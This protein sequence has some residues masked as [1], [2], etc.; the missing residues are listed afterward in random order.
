MPFVSRARSSAIDAH[1]PDVFWGATDRLLGKEFQELLLS[2]PWSKAIEIASDLQI[3]PVWAGFIETYHAIVD[4]VEQN[5]GQIEELI[6]RS[7]LLK[8]VPGFWGVVAVVRPDKWTLL[9]WT[10]HILSW[11][12]G[13][14]AAWAL[15]WRFGSAFTTFVKMVDHARKVMKAFHTSDRHLLRTRILKMMEDAKKA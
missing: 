3:D 5:H 12:A 14:P 2:Q 8:R 11:L 13:V 7:Q 15:V 6:V 9:S 4:V 1:D 10:F